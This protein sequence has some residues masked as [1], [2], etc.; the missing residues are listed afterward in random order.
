MTCI[1]GLVHEDG[2]IIGGDTAGSAGYSRTH[3]ADTKVFRNGPYVMGFTTSYRM[4]QLL[5]YRLQ[6]PV[7]ATWDL[8]RF[9]ATDFVDAVRACLEAHGWMGKYENRDEG[10]SFLVA[11]DTSLYR[12][13]SDFQ[14]QRSAD[15]YD[16]VGSG[17]DIAK[18]AMHATAG[19]NLLPSERVLAALAAA[20]HHNAGVGGASTLMETEA[21]P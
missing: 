17:H 16:A 18:G 12:V 9:M 19:L 6:A 15:P 7:A 3:R 2:V 5:R 13:D 11:F 10:G 20:E 1:V 14:I 21:Q 4:G 8:D